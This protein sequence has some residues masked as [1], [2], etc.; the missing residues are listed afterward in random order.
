L[1]RLGGDEFGVLLLNCNLEDAERIAN[2][3]R[4]TVSEFRFVWQDKIFE[5][6]VSIGLVGVNQYSKDLTDVLSAADVACYS[7]KDAGRNRIHV[8]QQG[9][10]ELQKR[11]GEMQWV[12]RLQKAVDDNAFCLHYQTI[13]P[14]QT[15][16]P[17]GAHIEVLLRMVGSEGV[18]ILPGAFLPSAERYDLIRS[19]DQWVVQ[20]LFERFGRLMREK[21]DA[22]PECHDTYGINLS[23][24]SIDNL[25]FRQFL[26]DSIERFNIPASTLCFE[27]T[28]TSAIT[29]LAGARHFI[30]EL[31]ALGCEFALDDF[32]SGMSS[33]SY[34]KNLDVDYLK[35]DGSYVR[36]IND[37]PVDRALVNSVNQIGH[38]MGMNT[39]A[40]YAEDDA[41]LS[42]LKAIGVDY[43]QGYCL[44]TPQPIDQFF[45]S[46]VTS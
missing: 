35:I 25:E 45:T 18:F 36:D 12:N 5:I 20:H 21:Y 8:Y 31:K 1:A 4:M 43:A 10:L 11:R 41:C 17:S 6:G 29:N 22:N 27:I 24:K 13:E 2:T 15:S 32:G 37:D 14:L 16:A 23:G 40:E 28:E 3:L 39:I 42:I 26:V 9:D 7:A 38:V 19:V 44:S 33:F 46:S 30:E 34:L